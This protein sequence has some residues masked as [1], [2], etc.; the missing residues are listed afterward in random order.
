MTIYTFIIILIIIFLLFY[1]VNNNI[2][3]IE[4]FNNNDNNKNKIAIITS[5]YGNYDQIKNQENVLDRNLVDWYCFTD[6][7]NM[8]SDYWNIV[9]KPYHIINTENND[10]F[11]DF[12]NYYKNIKDK[13][14]YNMMC[15]KYYK[16]QPHQI[17]ILKKYDYY[18][19]IDGSIFLRDN[20]I[21]NVMILT[22]KNYSLINFKHS[23]RDNIK[24]EVKLSITMKKYKSQNIMDQYNAYIEDNFPDNSGLFE[25][26]VFIR[27]NNL[28]I[29][30]LFDLWWEN[31]LKY[32]YQDQ[33]SYPYV[34]WK[35]NIMPDYII[36]KNVFNNE[37]YTY[38]DGALN[39]NH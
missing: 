1:I 37:D 11:S 3:K 21:K 9:N 5:I 10:K 39:V 17:D 26:T 31:N 32:S 25:K 2:K 8:K 12:T 15:A 14:T 23:V 24:D 18:I 19:W 6:N 4:K 27:K 16:A 29:N 34:L 38:T 35:T 13:R 28:E 36:K 30:N 33:I 7:V 20:F 22:D